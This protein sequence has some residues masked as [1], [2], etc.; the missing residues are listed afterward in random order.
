M[1]TCTRRYNAIKVA[2]I[3]ILPFLMAGA[4]YGQLS[5]KIGEHVRCQDTEVLVP[6][7]VTDFDDIAAITLQIGIDTLKTRFLSVENIH[8][9]LAGGSVISNF[10]SSS[11]S[12]FIIW[13]SMVIANIGTGTLF[14]LK[15]DY[16]EDEAELV[17]GEICEIV[18]SDLTIVEAQ[19]GDGIIHPALQIE[20]QPQPLTVVEGEEAQ[21]TAGVIFPDAHQYLWQRND[22]NGWNALGN[23]EIFSG[24]ATPVLTI[25]SAPVAFNH[26]VF[27]CLIAYDDDCSMLTDSAELVVTPLTVINPQKE[28]TEKML[29]VYPNPCRQVLNYTLIAQGQDYSM[30]LCSLLGSVVRQQPLTETQGTIILD[31]V[32]PGLYF[33]Q[34]LHRQQPVETIKVI[35]R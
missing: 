30:Q 3:L 32:L 1:N 31:G 9:E 29:D 16:Y 19:L 34:L 33:M 5:V 14:D 24:V 17:F 4:L 18:L 6:V 2:A 8:P 21:F 12:I 7:E 27:R 25:D 26:D 23:N 28:A 15:L 10:V 35:V 20:E 22:G 13:Q 11:S